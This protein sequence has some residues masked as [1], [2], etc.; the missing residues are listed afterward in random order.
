MTNISKQAL[1]KDVQEKLFDQFTSLF[2]VTQKKQ[3]SALFN[4]L[5]TESEKIMFIK[6]VAVVFMLSQDCSTYTIAKTLHVSD[7]TARDTR[8]KYENGT[9]DQIE[10][11]LK[12]K[13]F[14]AQKFWTVVEVL[15]NGGLPSRA[16]S[17]RWKHVPGMGARPPKR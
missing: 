15:L 4:A 12:R 7:K 1:Q 13:N 8:V 9:F 16:G 10:K 3:M 17:E 5:F 14:D 2:M 6:R 11:L